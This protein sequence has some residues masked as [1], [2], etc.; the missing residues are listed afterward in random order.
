MASRA[1]KQGVPSNI[2]SASTHPGISITVIDF[3][4]ITLIGIVN[5]TQVWQTGRHE[6]Q[7][8]QLPTP[9]LSFRTHQSRRLA[10]P[11]FLSEL[12]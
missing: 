6:N 2:P 5:L 11:S 10:V 7:N 12:P 4:N 9:S 8:T 1:R 3:V